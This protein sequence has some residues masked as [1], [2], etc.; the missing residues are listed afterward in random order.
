M[1]QRERREGIQRKPAE[2]GGPATARALLILASLFTRHIVKNFTGSI[3]QRNNK[4]RVRIYERSSFVSFVSTMA[5]GQIF[6]PNPTVFIS[7][8]AKSSAA[9]QHLLAAKKSLWMNRPES[10][11]GSEDSDTDEDDYAE[12]IDQDEIF[13]LIREIYDPEHP[14]TLEELRVVSA[15]QISVEKNTVKVEFT[16]TVPHCG[17][18]LSIRVRLIRSL[19]TR[20][21]LDIVVKPGSHQSEH[22]VNKQLNDKERVAAALE[23]PA[24]LKT[25]EECLSGRD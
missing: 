9:S 18:S 24:L 17:M 10:G 12:A 6:N 2:P 16:P 11:F 4:K 20:F 1:R 7:T 13:D 25:V 21:K 15:P 3:V 22:A 5:N 8:S 19:P 23:N 14:N